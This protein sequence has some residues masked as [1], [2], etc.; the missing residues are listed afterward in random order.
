M[1]SKRFQQAY[2]A[3]VKAFFNNELTAGNCTTC[4]VGNMIS[5]SPEF[6]KDCLTEKFLYSNYWDKSFIKGRE[7]NTAHELANQLANIHSPFYEEPIKKELLNVLNIRLQ[8]IYT[9]QNIKR[10]TGYSMEELMLIEGTFEETVNSYILKQNLFELDN[11]IF[12]DNSKKE[13]FELESHYQGLCAVVD[14]LLS[15]EKEEVDASPY[16]AKFK[17]KLELVTV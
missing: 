11:D 10:H 7:V 16:K 5:N 4:A 13:Y 15:F 9:E 1:L 6:K 12:H 3:L 17:E 8:Q 2:D 14:V